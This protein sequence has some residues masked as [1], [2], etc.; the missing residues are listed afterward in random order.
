[1]ME[2]KAEAILAAAALFQ[3]AATGE[4]DRDEGQAT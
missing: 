3:R 1:M 2:E 4:R